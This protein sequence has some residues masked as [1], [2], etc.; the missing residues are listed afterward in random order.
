MKERSW[1]CAPFM[2]LRDREKENHPY[3]CH[4]APYDGKFEVEWFDKGSDGPHTLYYR[5][6][7]SQ[8]EYVAIP[9][10]SGYVTVE[11]VKNDTDYEL[12]VARDDG[13]AKSNIRFVYCTPLFDENASVIN[14][15]HP[16]DQQYNYGGWWIGFPSIIRVPSGKLLGIH[17][18]FGQEDPLAILFYSEDEGKTWHFLNEMVPVMAPRLF[19]NNGKLYVLG[20]HVC[21]GGIV[22]AESS[23][24]GKTWTEP[25]VLLRSMHNKSIHH[26]GNGYN[27]HATPELIHNGRI[28]IPFE[29]GSWSRWNN[30]AHDCRIMS[31]PVDSNLLDKNSWDFTPGAFL[32]VADFDF[33]DADFVTSIEGNLMLN[34]DGEIY[35]LAR[36]DTVYG[37]VKNG[38]RTELIDTAVL[39]K[40]KNFD[41]PMEYVRPVSAKVGNRHGFFIRKDEI[42]NT[43]IMFHNEELIT[44]FGRN[45]ISMSV[46]KD[47]VNWEKKA[48]L[49][50]VRNAAK[51]S[52]VSQPHFIFDG[53]DILYISRTAWG[54][55]HSEHNGNM[56][57]FHRLKNFRD[58]LK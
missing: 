54:K 47:M 32:D 44:K 31:A 15:I 37:P 22:I 21:A 43:Y 39:F 20:A 12:F 45:A 30:E 56:A 55:F 28:Y 17:E 52:T 16:D 9:L 14:Y 1:A 49:L 27:L 11:G 25:T 40:F 24:E 29:Q 6:R 57:T 5:L 18:V 33:P 34:D 7:D 10:T 42:T 26:K 2:P 48:T 4:I 23:D 19:M 38:R 50:D 3:I 36:L 41:Q 46:S 51:E 58:L 53:E 8:D 13:S 35:S